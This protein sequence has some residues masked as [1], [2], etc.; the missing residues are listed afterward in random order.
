M[1]QNVKRIL[2]ID[3]DTRY[4]YPFE[5]A[6]KTNG[7]DVTVVPTVSEGAALVTAT[8]YSLVIVDIMIPVTEEEEATDYPPSMTD[9]THKTGLVFYK[10]Y[11][12]MLAQRGIPLIVMT[13]RVDQGIADEFAKAGF[14]A[15]A[16][17]RK[18]EVRDS[19]VFLEKIRAVLGVSTVGGQTI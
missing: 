7:Y 2:W 4:I 1:E 12:D 10:R 11:R 6:L 16:F 5:V 13:V 9:E 19:D 17:V 15:G 18:F 3:N 8:K 14:P